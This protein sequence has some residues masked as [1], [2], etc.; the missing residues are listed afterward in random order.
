MGL[1]VQFGAG[2]GPVFGA[3]E[4]FS[5]LLRSVEGGVRYEVCRGLAGRLC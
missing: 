1:T 3:A 4:A 5:L 2:G